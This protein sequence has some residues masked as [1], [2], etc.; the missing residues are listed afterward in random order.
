M[1]K[2]IT[3]AF[4]LLA[5]FIFSASIGQTEAELYNQGLKY[6][7]QIN[8]KKML[9]VFKKLVEMDPTNVDYLSN[10]SFAYSKVGANLTDAKLQMKFY[11]KAKSVASEAKNLNDNH[12]FAHYSYALALARENEN[13]GTKAKIVNAKEIKSECDRVIALDPK[14]AGAYHVMGRWHRTFAGFSGFEKAMVNTFYGGTPEGGSYKVALE[15]FQKAIKIEPWY[16]LHTYELA[17]TYHQM[18]NDEYA[19]KFLQKAMEL[20]QKYEDAVK[21]FEK[22]KTMLA[23]LK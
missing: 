7:K 19:I 16:M 3:L 13:A 23:E 11:A 1:K 18:G 10:L 14:E 9:P 8:N 4:T 12:A 2:V 21:C 22:C 5:L 17:M 6:K 20:P 15:M